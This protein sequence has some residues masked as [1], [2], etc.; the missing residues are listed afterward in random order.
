MAE[1]G[2]SNVARHDAAVMMSLMYLMLRRLLELVVLLGRA[3]SVGDRL[4]QVR[5]VLPCEV[6]VVG[7]THPLFGRLLRAWSFRRLNGILHLV[8]ELPD[9]S[10]GTIRADATDVLGEALQRSGPALVLD[11]EG[12][13]AVRAERPRPDGRIHS[14]ETDARR[15]Q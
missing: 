3:R 7:E 12:L 15:R 5:V 13:R 6:R 8:V 9:G 2:A 10:P 14:A 11:G 4:Q 1:A